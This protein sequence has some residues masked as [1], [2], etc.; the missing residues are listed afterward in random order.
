MWSFGASD[1][2]TAR[3]L[4]LAEGLLNGESHQLDW[5]D[6]QAYFDSKPHGRPRVSR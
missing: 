5:H 1:E 3:S 2:T 6:G 4:L